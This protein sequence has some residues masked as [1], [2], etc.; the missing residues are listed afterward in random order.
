[1]AATWAIVG[2][3]VEMTSGANKGGKSL[4]LL[5]PDGYG[6]ELHERPLGQ[7]RVAA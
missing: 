1:M 3:P 2:G 6:F 5:D 7:P 4:Y